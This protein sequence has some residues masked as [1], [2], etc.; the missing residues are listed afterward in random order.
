MVA[1]PLLLMPLLT[2]GMGVPSAKI[3]GRAREEVPKVMVLGGEDS[4][5]VRAELDQLE[6]IYRSFPLS[7]ITPR[8]F[9]TR[10]SVRPWKFQTVSTRSLHAARP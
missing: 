2:V 10:R 3:V 8:K 5:N 6:P 7:P 4:P 1:V 9:Q